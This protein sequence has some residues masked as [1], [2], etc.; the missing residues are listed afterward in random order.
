MSSM[1]R[2]ANSHY[3]QMNTNN[4][5][6]NHHHHTSNHDRFNNS[7]TKSS[8]VCVVCCHTVPGPHRKAIFALGPCDHPI[9]YH[10]STKM[11]ALCSQNECPICRQDLSEVIFTESLDKKYSDFAS[12]NA[13]IYNRHFKIYFETEDCLEA[14]SWLLKEKCNI[15]K[16]R[17]PPFDKV[18][19][20]DEHLRTVH[21]LNLCEL[22]VK[23]LKIF[24]DER[25]YY[26][27]QELQSHLQRGDAN[28]KSYQGHPACKFCD[29]R[30][31]DE[32]ELNFHLRRDH[33]FCHLCNPN[34]I[35]FYDTYDDLNRHFRNDHYVC[36]EMPCVD[37]QFLVFRSEIDLQA[38]RASVHCL[39]RSE[40]R[41]ARTLTLSFNP[42]PR[43]RGGEPSVTASFDEDRQERRR[44]HNDRDEHRNR[45]TSPIPELDYDLIGAAAIAIR[46]PQQLPKPEDFP[47]L[48]ESSTTAS[49]APS[50][51]APNA[52]AP[53][54]KTGKKGNAKNSANPNARAKSAPKAA[55]RFSSKFEGSSSYRQANEEEF[56]ALCAFEVASLANV[57]L[58]SVS[59]AETIKSKAATLTV[60]DKKGKS[61]KS[62]SN[63]GAESSGRKPQTTNQNSTGNNAKKNPTSGNE[64]PPGYED[65]F[66]SLPFK[67]SGNKKKKQ[68]LNSMLSVMN[69]SGPVSPP[70]F[71]SIRVV[72]Q[73]P[74]LEAGIDEE[75]SSNQHELEDAP[76]DEIFPPLSGEQD[77]VPK[78]GNSKGKVQSKGFQRDANPSRYDKSDKRQNGDRNN[79]DLT[80][81]S[82]A[83]LMMK[84][85]PSVPATSISKPSS[86][87]NTS[88]KKDSKLRKEQSTNKDKQK[89]EKS[90]KK[91]SPADK[92]S[93]QSQIDNFSREDTGDRLKN[94]FPKQS[95]PTSSSEN[96]TQLSRKKRKEKQP[97]MHDE[98]DE[99]N[100]F[101]HPEDF[102]LR[103]QK[104]LDSLERILNNRFPEFRDIS[105][106]FQN[107]RLSPDVYYQKCAD[108]FGTRLTSILLELIVLLPDIRK[109][110]QLLIAHEGYM[111]QRKGAIPKRSNQAGVWEIT[112]DGDIDFVV[113]PLCGQVLSRKDG[114][115]HITRHGD[116]AAR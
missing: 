106:Q 36:D 69:D 9:C 55:S 83:Q 94:G 89:N 22:C 12:K 30:Y 32:E 53:S 72:K 111:K 58:N 97:R 62:N 116:L 73:D 21:N 14:F 107:D 13:L 38:H 57:R 93:S 67:V 37:V 1:N 56:P 8:T 29:K 49:A 70:N 91:S 80:L 112:R 100:Q 60:T 71:T 18:E 54:S 79:Q 11:R 104:L 68:A 50:V 47:S 51:P 61:N 7:N 28:D 113:C 75:F 31:M 23:N 48:G 41:H 44:K 103:N 90:N 17:C 5:G 115:D 102:D 15:C 59:L 81:N 76:F 4:H 78:K 42:F 74:L 10:C 95:E 92:K 52:D 39:T 87:K 66:P 35:V 82:L 110:K 101:I 27:R 114:P 24:S 45:S 65:V 105:L 63:K 98:S 77:S 108:M 64:L 46:P 96:D 99:D 20:L 25:K 19:Q 6:G 88:E 84:P 85:K 3:G 33:F 86:M 26:R 2:R 34:K 109:Q 43:S 16:G 40:A